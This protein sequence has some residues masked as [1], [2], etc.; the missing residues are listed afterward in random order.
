MSYV[1]TWNCTLQQSTY[2]VIH[3][4]SL[5]SL[6]IEVSPMYLC[7][8]IRLLP[9]LMI[10]PEDAPSVMA[11]P[12]LDWCQAF[13]LHH[14]TSV[15]RLNH[16]GLCQLCSRLRNAQERWVSIAFMYVCRPQHEALRHQD[17]LKC[18]LHSFV[19]S[20]TRHDS[21]MSVPLFSKLYR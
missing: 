1:H 7:S 13:T 19:H 11:T 3:H 9:A 16:R 21:E 18:I 4:Q 17:Y 2:C 12:E 10:S 20:P 15:N 6:S 14:W 5:V 8:S